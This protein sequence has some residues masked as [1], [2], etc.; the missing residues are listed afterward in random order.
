[1]SRQGAFAE[2]G[3]GGRVGPGSAGNQRDEMSDVL[4][5]ASRR[6]ER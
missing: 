5:K 3:G 2:E 4:G 6:A 1:M